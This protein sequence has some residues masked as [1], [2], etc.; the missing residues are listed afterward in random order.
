MSAKD[1]LKLNDILADRVRLAI[2]ADLAMRED[3]IDF[4]AILAELELTKGNLSAHIRKLED[5]GLVQ[6]TKEFVDRKPKTTFLATKKGR[7][8]LRKY[9]DALARVLGK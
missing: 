6:V 7:T 4:T 8:E 1:I 9:L 2:M 3:A 5:A